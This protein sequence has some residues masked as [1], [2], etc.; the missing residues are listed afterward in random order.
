M[1]DFK[2]IWYDH[3]PLI[4][5][6]YNNNYHFSINISPYDDL[7]RRRCRSHVGWFKDGESALIGP[8]SIHYA[9]EKVQILRDRLNTTQS[10]QKSYADVRRRELKKFKVDD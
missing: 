9:M 7:Y 8:D 2:G 5:L 3:L 1:I 4:E 6:T 10:R